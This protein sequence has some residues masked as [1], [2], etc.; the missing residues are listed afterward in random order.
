MRLTLTTG[1][2]AEPL[3]LDE[4]KAHLRVDGTEEDGLIS[5]LITTSRLHVEAALGLALI[6]QTWRWQADRWPDAGDGVIELGVRPVLTVDAV[7]VTGADGMAAVLD[8]ATY[9]VDIAGGVAR[10]A[11]LADWPAPGARLG[12]AIIDFTAGYGSAA[13]DVPAPL[14]QALK[15]LVAHWYEVREPVYVGTMAAR[16]PDTVSD[17]LAP[18]ARRRL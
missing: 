15:L 14:R 2:A 6:V 7:S 4:A 11:A 9:S 10:L 5:S 8:P 17:L 3:S 12:G 16:V 13:S 1:P 18:F